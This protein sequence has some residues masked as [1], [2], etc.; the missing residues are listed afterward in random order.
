MQLLWRGKM[1]IDSL[2]ERSFQVEAD[3]LGSILNT[4]SG[5]E[6]RL[7][8]RET[9]PPILLDGCVAAG[10]KGGHGAVRYAVEEYVPGRKVVFRFDGT[11]LT[12]DFQGH[13][14]FEIIPESGNVLLR[15]VI[16]A[17][18]NFKTWLKW[19]VVIEPLHDALIKDALDRAELALNGRVSKP[20]AWNI[21]VKILR[22]LL[23][24]KKRHM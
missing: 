17:R 13:H 1:K 19:K 6:D 18:G 14:Y 12:A 24:K 10:A 7:W 23:T 16:A 3:K 11:G 4:L 22:N 20:A 8:P 5:S 15:H 2:H 9:W 21:R